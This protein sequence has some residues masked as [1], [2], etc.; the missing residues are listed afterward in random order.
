MLKIK[1]RR[2]LVKLLATYEHQNQYHLVFRCAEGGNLV[3]LW[4]NHTRNPLIDHGRICWFAEQ[5]HGLARGLEGIHDAKPSQ[6]GAH[7]EEAHEGP[8]KPTFPNKVTSQSQEPTVKQE[9]VHANSWQGLDYGRHGDIKPQNVLWF[10]QDQNQFGHGELKICDF[11]ATTFTTTPAAKI[12]AT[13]AQV[14]WTFAGPEFE[15]NEYVSRSFDIWSLGCT[16][17]LFIT[18]ILLGA[19]GLEDFTQSRMQ[20]RTGRHKFRVDNFYNLIR[21][22]EDR[23]AEVKDSV[24]KVSYPST[25]NTL[26]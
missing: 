26:G 4:E 21:D 22:G 3:D 25:V 19:D 12:P 16:Y 1:N 17:L 20:E 13:E 11:G 8:P 23:R 5:C 9:E 24:K 18:W 2:H 15:T 14:T 10:S 6:E 7:E